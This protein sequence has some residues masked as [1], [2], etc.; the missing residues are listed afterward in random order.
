MKTLL[1]VLVL[2][3]LVSC[4]TLHKQVLTIEMQVV[5]TEGNC[6]QLK[7][8]EEGNQTNT[9][10]DPEKV[11]EILQN[12]DAKQYIDGVGFQWAGKEVIGHVRKRYPNLTLMQTET[13]C[14][15]G[16]NDW[17]ALEYTFDLM[18][19]YFTNGVS[20]YLYWNMV[21]DYTGSS[22]WGWQQ[23]AM[24]TIGENNQVICNPEFYLMKHVSYFVQ[25]GARHL[26]CSDGNTM[27]FM[28]PDNK[29]VIVT[30]NPDDTPQTKHFMLKNKRVE[31][32]C[33]PK[34]LSTLVV[35]L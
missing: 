10:T 2:A 8:G 25:K 33:S 27:V 28:N 19:H 7:Q 14:G 35:Q 5:S 23:N 30:Y 22:K 12:A 4:N 17:S 3:L 29:V 1:S 18:K 34:A 16:S 9:A 21:L 32:T 6:W 11:D 20:S 15:N 31:T 26:T 24:I 13:E